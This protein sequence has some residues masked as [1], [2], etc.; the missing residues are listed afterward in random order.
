MVMAAG[1]AWPSG[2]TVY[3]DPAEARTDIAAAL[4]TAAQTHKR[5]LLDF[6]GNWCGDCI[7]LEMYLHNE[8]NLSLLEANFVLVHVN[9][10]HLDENLDIAE[11]YQVPVTRGVPG[12]AVLSETGK[13][14][15]SARNKELEQAVQQS[16]PAAVTRF[17]VQW[18]PSKQGC[19]MMAVNC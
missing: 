5:V 2:R 18:K 15:Y 1:M 12:V 10:G 16:D 6:G 4:K 3:P 11:R 19:S 9:V 13:L 7:V 14:L 17:L 8:E